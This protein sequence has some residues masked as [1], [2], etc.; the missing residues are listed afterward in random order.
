MAPE[1]SVLVHHAVERDQGELDV[2]IEAPKGC[3][4]PSRGEDAGRIGTAYRGHHVELEPLACL[5]VVA[6]EEP[7]RA[8][9]PC[10]ERHEPPARECAPEPAAA[11]RSR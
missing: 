6:E 11:T 10:A 7:V 2:E 5:R 3:C 8:V 9:T 1:A 4:R